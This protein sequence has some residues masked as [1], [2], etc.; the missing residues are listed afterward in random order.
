MPRGVFSARRR[1]HDKIDVIPEETDF[2]M[3]VECLG[4]LLNEEGY[5]ASYINGSSLSI[6]SKG[7]FFGSHGFQRVKGLESYLGYETEPRKNVWGMD[8]DLLFERLAD[9]L[10]WLAR[11]EKPF[12]LTTLTLSTHG[13][14]G[15]PEK[16]C[17]PQGED[18]LPLLSAIRCSGEHVVGLMDEIEAL[19]LQD[20][21]LV[22]LLSDHLAFL[23][24]LHMD[25]LSAADK[26]RN[27]VVVLGTDIAVNKREGSLL[28]VYPTLLELLGFEI[29]GHRAGLGRSLIGDAPTLVESYGLKRT[30]RAIKNNADLQ[31]AIWADT[32]GL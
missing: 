5:N 1:I 14:D 26:R 17:V 11:Q 22:V 4:D 32:P 15:Y 27:F 19:G 7:A 3:G 9:E 24:S 6:F 29:E 12:M 2:L 10:R 28:D 18:E 25:L 31:R 30:N 8:D 13:P 21:T 23:N 16:S 20:E